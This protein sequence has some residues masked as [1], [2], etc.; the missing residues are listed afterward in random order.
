M[1]SSDQPDAEIGEA[2]TPRIFMENSLFMFEDIK[3]NLN[4]LVNSGLWF[5]DDNVFWSA[6]HQEFNK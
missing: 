4:R 6:D 1:V 3:V 2:D 5:K